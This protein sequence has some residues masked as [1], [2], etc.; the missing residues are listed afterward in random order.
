MCKSIAAA[1]FVAIIFTAP[2]ASAQPND[3]YDYPYCL[4]GKE[5]G[6][7]G[8]CQFSSYEQC[9]ATA[10]ATTSYCGLNPRF[11][12]SLQQRTVRPYHVR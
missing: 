4:Q 5:Y 8:L 7:P 2:P 1:A 9:Q 11:A 6:L 3:P 12:Y 10:R